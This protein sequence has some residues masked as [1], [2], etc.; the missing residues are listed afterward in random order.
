MKKKKRKNPQRLFARCITLCILALIGVSVYAAD[1]SIGTFLL[2]SAPIIAAPFVLMIPEG[3]KAAMS[4]NEINAMNELGKQ[5]GDQ[6]EKLEKGSITQEQLNTSF[7]TL[8][9]DHVKEYGISKETLDTLAN[10][11]KSQGLELQAMK[12]R[13]NGGSEGKGKTLKEQLKEWMGTDECKAAINGNGD[14][15]LSVKAAVP[16]SAYTDTL[17]TT[18]GLLPLFNV[19]PELFEWEIDRTIH[20]A[21]KERNHF[22]RLF[23]KGNTNAAFIIWFNRINKQG[24]AVFTT[25][26]GLKPLMSWT[27][28]KETAQPFKIPVMVKI[29]KEML[30]D[31]DFIEGEIRRVL[32]EELDDKIDVAL[33]SGDG[34]NDTPNG[35]ATWAAGY[36]GTGLDGTIERAN[37]VDAIRAGI[38]QLRNNN[39][40]A[41]VLVVSPTTKA[42]IDLLKDANGNYIKPET[43]AI[44]RPLR[45]IET[46]KIPENDF[47]LLD[48]SKVILKSKGGVE[49]STG[50]GVNQMATTGNRQYASDFEIN[51]VSILVER[52]FFMYHNSIDETAALYDSLATVKAALQQ[53]TP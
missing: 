44:L 45:I 50:W 35:V 17:G 46:T 33:L 49:I 8:W 39:H 21:P 18:T 1:V 32:R 11:L 19:A 9:E 52:R 26:Y 31:V 14:S 23:Y 12:T 34:T 15:K 6:F 20:E 25:E 29:S 37:D 28:E 41:D 27:Y 51:A 24:G 53:P 7:K 43:D 48:T 47:L 30:D 36:G 38:L 22:W 4:E 5:M 3:L 2:G 13:L 16:L 42:R 10:T 40:T